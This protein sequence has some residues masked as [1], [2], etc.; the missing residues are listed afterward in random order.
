HESSQ[1]K[2][3]SWESP[4]SK[5]T[6]DSSVLVILQDACFQSAYKV[7]NSRRMIAEMLI[8]FSSYVTQK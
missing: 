2:S 1:I 3:T 7:P 4:V 6:G 8:A 5:K